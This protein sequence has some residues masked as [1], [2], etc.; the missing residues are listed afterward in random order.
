MKKI[1]YFV[2]GFLVLLSIS[3]YF[4]YS[5]K[6]EEITKEIFLEKSIQ[7]RKL[8]IDEIKRKQDNTLNMAFILSQDE[9]LINALK[10]KNKSLLNYNNTLLFLHDN[11]DYKNL[12]L[13]IVDKEGKKFL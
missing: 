8:F 3:Y 2:I 6:K 4:Y 10:T 12:W 7:M 5:P 1:L 13:Q 11:S 9:N